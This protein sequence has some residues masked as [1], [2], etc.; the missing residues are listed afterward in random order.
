MKRILTNEPDVQVF[1]DF[2]SWTGHEIGLESRQEE[3]GLEDIKETDFGAETVIASSKQ[4]PYFNDTAADKREDSDFGEYVQEAESH[5]QEI[6]P[7]YDTEIIGRSGPLQDPE[8]MPADLNS[9]GQ[10]YIMGERK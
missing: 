6:G 5:V 8:E 4:F 10:V 1:A 9:A 7:G 3:Y 2:A